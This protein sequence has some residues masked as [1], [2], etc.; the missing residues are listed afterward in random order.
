MSSSSPVVLVHGA[1]SAGPDAWP[2][3]AGEPG[4]HAL[5]RSPEGDHPAR[6]ARRV[7]DLLRPVGG[8]H[9]VAHSYGANAAL[10]AARSEPDLVRSVVLLEPACFDLARGMPAVEA[11]IT[12]MAPAHA[13]ADDPAVSGREFFELFARGMGFPPPA[14][15]SAEHEANAARLRRLA[16]PWDT[17]LRPEDG[18]PVPTLVVAGPSGPLYAETAIALAALGADRLTL[19]GVGHRVQDDPRTTGLLRDFWSLAVQTGPMAIEVS[20][21]T[22]PPRDE[23]AELYG[24]VGWAAYTRDLDALE[25]ALEGSTRVVTAR[26]DG[27]LVG[28]ARVVSDRATIA[29]LQDVLVLPEEQRNGV[30]TRLV[31][32]ALVP[33][34]SVRQK[35]LLTDDEPGQRAFYES[36]GFAEIRDL[37]DGSLRAFVKLD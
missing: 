36:L 20:S 2:L 16:P 34:A 5:T 33:F 32:E 17:G 30:G 27:R 19:E 28:L 7:L 3:Q 12:E 9:V 18:L 4:W 25:R 8:G 15:W 35:V 24:A 31:T 14:S 37:D 23:L 26:R 22:I 11:H 10:L 21:G 1:G 6:D 13:V 29:Y